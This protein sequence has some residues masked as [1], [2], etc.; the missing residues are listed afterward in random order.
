M[1]LN[2]SE[3]YGT[4]K[5]PQGHVKSYAGE[6]EFEIRD[7]RGRILNR[8][9]EPNIVKIFAKEIL[10]HRLPHSKIWDPTASAGSG[11]WVSHNIDLDEFSIKYMAFGASF[12]VNGN[13]LDVADTR[14]YSKDAVSGGYTPVSLGAGAEYDGGLVN[15]I[16]ISEPSRPLKRIERIYFETSYQPAGTPL[17]Q[18]D[19]RAINNVMVVETTLRK[20]EYNG[21]AISASDHFT[22]TEVALVGAKELSTSLGAC[23][24]SP[25]D[26]F[27]TGTAD[28]NDALLVSTSG[29][30]TISISS[31]ESE[32][33]MIKEGDQIKIVAV[34][35]TA[36][37]DSVLNQL[38]PYYLVIS[39]ATGGRDITLDRVPVD[40]DNVA[41][42][43]DIGV[44]RDGFRIFSH[45][46]LTA[47]VK[48][49]SS[50]EIVV[51]WRIIMN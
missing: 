6:I 25:R 20:D 17:L 41:L 13:P 45:R 50:F 42:S 32:V 15:P 19:V 26:I 34:G 31:T 23:E 14:F 18:A 38:N 10:A 8:V 5:T 24:C 21:Y 22:L 51:R 33:D 40:A 27:L 2:Y 49:S 1:D 28:N 47:P 37:A 7:A 35:T 12:D 16:P 30:A 48:K 43:G 29:A 39:K 9:R 11:A 3:S 44:L 36:A 46:I 4:A